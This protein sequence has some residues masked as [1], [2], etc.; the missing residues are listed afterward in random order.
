MVT[1]IGIKVAV[2]GLEGHDRYVTKETNHEGAFSRCIL[3]SCF[4]CYIEPCIDRRGSGGLRARRPRGGLCGPGR[5]GGSSASRRCLPNRHRKR[6]GSAT[7]R[8]TLENAQAS[9]DMASVACAPHLYVQMSVIGESVS[10]IRT[11]RGG[12]RCLN[13]GFGKNLY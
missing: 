12:Y 9:I 10:N 4:R 3:R 2:T 5:G 7:L 13:S 11:Y 6:R 1:V 8:L